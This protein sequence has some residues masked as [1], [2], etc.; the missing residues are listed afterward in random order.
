M[1]FLFY[2]YV[3]LRYNASNEG[4]DEDGPA[5]LGEWGICIIKGGELE[6]VTY[7]VCRRMRF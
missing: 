5:I 7:K 4:R 6:T 3:L 2:S 1:G